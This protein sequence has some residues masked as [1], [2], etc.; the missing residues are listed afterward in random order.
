M[1]AKPTW[2]LPST[3]IGART[4]GRISRYWMYR[5]DSP[6]ARAADQA[7]VLRGGG[8]AQGDDRLDVTGADGHDDEEREDERRNREDGVDEPHEHLVDPAAV[9]PGDQRDRQ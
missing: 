9:V 5:A 6:R 4:F 7:H 2:M 8:D 1:S 3:M